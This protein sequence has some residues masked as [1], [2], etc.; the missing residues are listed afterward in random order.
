MLAALSRIFW[1]SLRVHYREWAKAAG[2]ATSGRV[3]TGAVT[4]VH[5]RGCELQVVL[6]PNWNAEQRNHFHLELTVHEWVLA[7]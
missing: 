3:E 2:H 6:T 5:P 7:R 1:E 4:G